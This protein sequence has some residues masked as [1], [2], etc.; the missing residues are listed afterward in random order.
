MPPYQYK[1]QKDLYVTKSQKPN[2]K[3]ILFID[4]N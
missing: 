2:I 1:F 4:L 3:I